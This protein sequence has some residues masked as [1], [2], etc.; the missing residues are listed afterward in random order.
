MSLHRRRLYLIALGSIGTT[1]APAGDRE[2]A[3]RD[4]RRHVTAAGAAVSYRIPESSLQPPPKQT[5]MG[6]LLWT[7]QLMT[8]GGQTAFAASGHTS[9]AS[10]VPSLSSSPSSQLSLPLSRSVCAT[11]TSSV[12]IETG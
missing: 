5:D 12:E 6:M 2:D 10:G 7:P 3:D 1:A 11:F 4:E 8:F 9:T